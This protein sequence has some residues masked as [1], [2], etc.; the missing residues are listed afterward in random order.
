[1]LRIVSVVVFFLVASWAF[2]AEQDPRQLTEETGGKVVL[3]ASRFGAVGDG[4]HNDGRTIQRAVAELCRQNRPAVLQFEAGKT[5]RVEDV[6]DIRLF[7]LEDC[8][9]VTIDGKG[10]TFLLGGDVRFALLHGARN[11]RLENFSIDYAP[12]PFYDGLIVGKNREEKYVD[13]RVFDEHEMPPLGGPTR[14]GGEQAYFGMLWTDGTYRPIGHHFYVTDLQMAN[15]QKPNDHTVRVFTDFKRFDLVR[16]NRHTISLPVRGVAHR[17]MDGATIRIAECENVVV[18]NVNVWSAPWFAFQVFRNRG[19]VTFHH[20]DI[21]PKPDANRRMS[22]W[23]DGFHVKGNR[24]RLRFEACHLEGMNDDAFNV[25]THMSRVVRVVSPTEIQVR[26]VYPLEIVPFEPGDAITFYSL[27]R[28]GIAGTARLNRCDGLQ[29]TEYLDNERPAAP[30]LTLHLSDPIATLEPGDRLWNDTSA[31]PDTTIRHCRIYQSCRFQ[32]PVT[33]EDC[34][35][36][37]FSWYHSENV[38]GPIPSRTVIKNSLLRLGRGNP[39]LA[40]SFDGSIALANR[41]PAS[42]L[43]AAIGHVLL[44]DNTIDGQVRFARIGQ[45]ELIKNR[46]LVPRSDLQLESCDHVLLKDN[47]LGTARIDTISQLSVRD[48]ETRQNIRIANDR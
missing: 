8:S 33:I 24:A 15:S 37:A 29:E 12:L 9:D 10:A 19:A 27:K 20:V 6:A 35:I 32:S 23:R 48:A 1:M 5:Y 26:Q 30:L 2:C 13:V 16:E 47:Y 22:S 14:E 25:S 39:V 38:E 44:Q 41:S 18:E 34:E 11:V 42:P 40:A 21:R 7:R 46:F 45:L 36:T 4:Q 17:C 43:Q 3:T 31:N 28:G